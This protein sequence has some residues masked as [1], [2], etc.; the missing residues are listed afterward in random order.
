MGSLPVA[1]TI[2][3]NNRSK[4]INNYVFPADIGSHG[5]M[6]AFREYDYSSLKTNTSSPTISSRI[7]ETVILPLPT[8]ME[9]RMSIRMQRFDQGALGDAIS[10]IAQK[11]STSSGPGDMYDSIKNEAGKLFPTGTEVGK[12]IAGAL[13]GNGTGQ[14]NIADGLRYIA[15][16]TLDSLGG[17]KNID[18]GTGT[19]VNPK[20]ALYFDGVDMKQHSFNWTLMPR[21][22]NESDHIQG[23]CSLLRRHSL[24]TYINLLSAAGAGIKRAM[25]RFPSVVDIYLLGLSEDYYMKFKPSMIQN[26]SYNYA[27]S[28]QAV[29]RGGKPAI[30]QVNL[31]LIE[32]DIWTAE[33]YGAA[34][35]TDK[36]YMLETIAKYDGKG[37]IRGL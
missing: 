13:S 37:N 34:S 4:G 28:G 20:A 17:G 22:E 3:Q 1:Q 33:D 7:S 15:R 9:D 35:D 6:L 8:N 24:P 18:A 21:S 10:R 25:F 29:L 14:D 31:E 32:T 2:A 26:I 19:T 23:I 12:A 16:S 11:A 27:P 30:V 5:I 36:A